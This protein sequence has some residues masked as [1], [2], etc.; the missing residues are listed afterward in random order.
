MSVPVKMKRFVSTWEE[1][2]SRFYSGVLLHWALV[3]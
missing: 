2:T 3:H 1:I